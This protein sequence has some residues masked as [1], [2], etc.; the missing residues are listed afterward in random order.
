MFCYII[1][2]CFVFVPRLVQAARLAGASLRAARYNINQ[3]P[4]KPQTKASS[5]IFRFKNLI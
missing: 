1:N 2:I 4:Q 5:H 3:K